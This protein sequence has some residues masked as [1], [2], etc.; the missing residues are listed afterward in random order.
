MR[1]C[2]SFSSLSLI[3][4]YPEES[5]IAESIRR[6]AFCIALILLGWF[7]TVGAAL[8]NKFFLIFYIFG[9]QLLGVSD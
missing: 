6:S 3:C 8:I 1:F 7:I 4:A 2:S 9:V 5:T